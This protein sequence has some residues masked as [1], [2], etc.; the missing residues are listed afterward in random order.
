[1]APGGVEMIR[2]SFERFIHDV[3]SAGAIT[4]Q[5]VR[6]LQRDII[7]DGIET[8]DEADLLIALDRAVHDKDPAWSAC[9]IQTVVDFVVWTSRPTGHVD[10]EAATWLVA[11]LGCGRG[12]T[13]V[14]MAIAFD[15]VRESETSDEALVAFVMR[16]AGGRSAV[17]IRP[18]AYDLAA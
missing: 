3:T 13:E 9:V 6:R 4:R 15:V 10:R 8:R 17:S 2:A 16:W 5:D 18:P 11:S 14:A 1:M 7:P 12:P